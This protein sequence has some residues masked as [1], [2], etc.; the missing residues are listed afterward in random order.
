MCLYY[1]FKKGGS[2][3]PAIWAYTNISAYFAN[4]IFAYSIKK[5]IKESGCKDICIEDKEIFH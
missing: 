2:I 4:I 5:N 1:L 3:I